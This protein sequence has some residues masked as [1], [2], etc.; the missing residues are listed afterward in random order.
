MYFSVGQR[1]FVAALDVPLKN[2]AKICTYLLLDF[3]DEILTI[4]NCIRTNAFLEF[5]QAL[6]QHDGA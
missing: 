1:D 4:R 2:N 6:H 3:V 5:V